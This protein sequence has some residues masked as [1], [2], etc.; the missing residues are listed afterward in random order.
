[1]NGGS[2]DEAPFF[3]NGAEIGAREHEANTNDGKSSGGI[4]GVGDGV[5]GKS[6]KLKAG[7]KENSAE[8]DSDNIGVFDDAGKEVASNTALKKKDAVRKE[9]DIKGNNETAVGDN[10]GGAEGAGD[11]RVAEEG[12]VVEDEGELGFEAELAFVEVFVED[13]EGGEDEGKHDNDAANEASEEKVGGALIKVGGEG[14]K[15][16]GGHEDI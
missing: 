8:D 6:G 15:K 5:G 2:E 7:E 11:E 3:E 13:K 10:A 14:K 12:G 16:G 9:S 4:A 1:M